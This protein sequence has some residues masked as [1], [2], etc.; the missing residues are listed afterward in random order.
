MGNGGGFFNKPGKAIKGFI[1]NPIGKIDNDINK[2]LNIQKNPTP[3]QQQCYDKCFD[4][5]YSTN[6]DFDDKKKHNKMI[7]ENFAFS[8]CNKQCNK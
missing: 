2:M 1:S 5:S 3:E 8:H 7:S 4:S 6:P